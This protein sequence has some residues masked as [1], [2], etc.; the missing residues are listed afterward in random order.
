[1][2]FWVFMLVMVLLVPLTM[3]GFGRRFLTRP[4]TRINAVFGYRTTMSMKNKDTWTFAH[5]YC[6]RLWYRWGLLLL[7]LSAIAMLFVWGQDVDTV[8]TAG[9]ILCLLQVLPLA[10]AIIPTELALK[11]TFDRNGRRR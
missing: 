9:I 8:G 4:P 10:G 6:G 11:R 5:G 2:G 7:P 1:M 3:V